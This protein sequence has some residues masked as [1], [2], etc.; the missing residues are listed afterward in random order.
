MAEYHGGLL[1][2]RIFLDKW[3]DTEAMKNYKAERAKRVIGQVGL[4]IEYAIA[5]ILADA[6]YEG[7]NEE[8]AERDGERT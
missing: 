6:F 7:V 8:A 5:G 1:A 2:A 3:S 4:P